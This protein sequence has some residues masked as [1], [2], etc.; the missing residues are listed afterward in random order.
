[1]Y[2]IYSGREIDDSKMNIEHII[3]LSLGGCNDFSIS[4]EKTLNSVLGSKVDGKMTNDFL[5]ALQRIKNTA[6]GHSNKLPKFNVKSSTEDGKPLVSTFVKDNLLVFDPI[7]KRYVEN[8]NKVKMV[9]K[10][11]LDTRIKFVIKVALATGFFLFG[12]DITNY[13]DC[14]SLRSVMMSENLQELLE[15]SP[16]KINGLRFY[17]SLHP[18]EERDRIWVDLYKMYCQCYH[19]T[20]VLWT[21]SPSSI[22]V[23]VGIWGEFIG[24]I[25]FKADVEKMPR[26]KNTEYWLGH[27]LICENNK[28]I[29][30]SWRAALLDLCESQNLINEDDLVAAKVFK[31]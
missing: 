8:I 10:I 29:R 11:E 7:D 2:C 14:D 9:T 28:L 15:A 26:I 1:M 12:K 31:G 27:I 22:I 5:I 20:N 13:V 30:K 19:S 17:D 21:Y 16:E 18:I 24:C 23:H 25:N 4:V 3:P 6:I